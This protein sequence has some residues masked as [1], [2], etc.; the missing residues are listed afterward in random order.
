MLFRRNRVNASDPASDFVNATRGHVDGAN[1]AELENVTFPAVAACMKHFIG[2]SNSR[3]GRD[4]TPV[5]IPHNIL[6]Q[7]FLPSFK[8][9]IEDGN[10]LSAMENYIELNGRPMVSS[11]MYLSFLLREQ[12]GFQHVLT[13]D[14]NEIWNLKDFHRQVGSYE[15]AMRVAMN[16]T[17]IDM[18]M[19]STPYGPFPNI[20][21]SVA[22]AARRGQLSATRLNTSKQRV[23]NLKRTLGLTEVSPVPEESDAFFATAEHRKAAADATAQSITL[24]QNNRSAAND[25]D[26]LLPLP[27]DLRDV[28]IAVVGQACNSTPL[29]AGGWTVHW[30]GTSDPSEYPYGSTV[31]QELGKRAPKEITF[32]PGCNV[33]EHSTCGSGALAEAY[34]NA[35][36]ADYVVVCVGERHYAEEP[37]DID[38]LRLPGEQTSMV[39]HLRGVNAKLVVVLIEGRPRLLGTIPGDAPAI[40]HAYLPGPAGGKAIV[41]VL[42][43]DV[44]PSGRLPLTYPRVPNDGPLQ[45]W[46]KASANFEG[47]HD[48]KEQ[49]PFGHGLS[50]SDFEYTHL[51]FA[52]VAYEFIMVSVTVT[53]HGPMAGDHAVLVFA[54]QAF[55]VITPEVK[56][57][58]GV[59]KEHWAVNETKTIEVSFSIE[60]ISFF[61]EFNCQMFQGSP[62]TVFAGDI[63]V[64]QPFPFGDPNGGTPIGPCQ[65]WGNY[66]ES[67]GHIG[68][69]L[70]TPPA[71]PAPPPNATPDYF[72]SSVV[73]F[74]AGIVG[75]IIIVSLVRRRGQQRELQLLEPSGV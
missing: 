51:S 20:A 57:L 46:R 62:V 54:T 60:K 39:H 13:T 48:F 30:Q 38:D 3:T 45:Y 14:Y 10:V 70:P 18:A 64:T 74:G 41:D 33:T 25:G 28:R 35:R 24:L 68:G 9:A 27:S 72:M 56:L 12:L 67:H 53:N 44:N 29:M 52:V 55:R 26:P 73:C 66:Y 4:R 16:Q 11:N 37:G 21:E 63:N 75:T 42:M 49:W 36:F 22:G 40:V 59:V 17:S 5:W 6:L 43:G 65:A 50:Y 47:F 15:E 7:Y 71:P 34:A 23:W 8:T 58:H 32:A 2:Y 19:A 31:L 1:H 61:D 69:L